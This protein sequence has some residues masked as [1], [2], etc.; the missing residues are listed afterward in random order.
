[1]HAS[2]LTPNPSPGVPGEG[3][4]LFPAARL[5][6]PH[7]EFANAK[8]QRSTHMSVSRKLLIAAAGVSWLLL[9]VV[10]AAAQSTKQAVPWRLA[11]VS[12]SS[13]ETTNNL[14]DLV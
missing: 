3:G 1:M 7:A 2:A 11:L 9:S 8:A 4:K 10:S 12:T 5:K 14:I 13:S 6:H